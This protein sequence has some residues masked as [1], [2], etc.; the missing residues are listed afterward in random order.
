[1]KFIFFDSCVLLSLLQNKK[2]E[3][4]LSS[5]L[6]ILD[7]G[8]TGL[9]VPEQ[10][11]NEI[12]RNKNRIV[13]SRKNAIRTYRKHAGNL[14]PLLDDGLL[15]SLDE[16][17]AV[18]DKRIPDWDG[19]SDVLLEKLDKILDHKNTTI[20]PTTDQELLLAS[21]RALNKKAPFVKNKNSIGDALLIESVL[22]FQRENN[23]ETIYFVTLNTEDF[24]DNS[25][26]RKVHSDL[27]PIFESMNIQY[28][29]N[30]TEIIEQLLS[31]QMPEEIKTMF[32]DMGHMVQIYSDEF[33]P[34]CVRCGGNLIHSG[35]RVLFGCAG[36]SASCDKCGTIHMSL[37]PDY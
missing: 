28:S 27:S 22:K 14:K 37:D 26:K 7:K 21:K 33:P 9:L 18:V 10:L 34:S 12:Q 8:V 16:I 20:I 36:I 32:E 2:M 31:I 4:M 3:P 11:Q 19:K 15:K 24:S 1:M 25:D 6:E 13:E 17:L 23:S 30:P 29:I 5:I 35:Y